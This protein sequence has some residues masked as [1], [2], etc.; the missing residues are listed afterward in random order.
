MNY[1][2][3]K[4][5]KSTLLITDSTKSIETILCKSLFGNF[6]THL[7][8]KKSPFIDI[9]KENEIIV[10]ST[11]CIHTTTEVYKHYIKGKFELRLLKEVDIDEADLDDESILCFTLFNLEFVGKKSLREK[12]SFIENNTIGDVRI[13]GYENIFDLE[14]LNKVPLLYLNLYRV[15][16]FDN[17]RAILKIFELLEGLEDAKISTYLDSLLAFIVNLDFTKQFSE[18][19]IQYYEE[20]D[21]LQNNH[22]CLIFQFLNKIYGKINK[23]DLIKIRNWCNPILSYCLSEDKDGHYV[24]LMDSYMEDLPVVTKNLISTIIVIYSRIL[25]ADSYLTAFSSNI[26]KPSNK[27]EQNCHNTLLK[28]ENLIENQKI[29]EI[30]KLELKRGIDQYLKFLKDNNLPDDCSPMFDLLVN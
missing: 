14:L 10:L 28:V 17:Q 7:T 1:Q 12:I 19:L 29:L 30:P 3:L 13:E 2:N 11:N 24:G 16:A 8:S 26:T 18:K 27:L 15:I 6:T 23:T 5:E 22:K 9:C 21:Y 4:S 25:N 20:I